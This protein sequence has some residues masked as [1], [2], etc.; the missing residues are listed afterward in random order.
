MARGREVRR[1]SEW[2]GRI[3]V[4]DTDPEKRAA[5]AL[6][7]PAVKAIVQ[8]AAEQQRRLHDTFNSPAVKALVQQAA[9]QQRRLHGTFN[10][11]AVKAIVQQAAEQQRRLHDTFNSP[12]VKA[13]V[14]Q[15]AE[16]QRRL[17]DTFNS[18]AAK[19]IVQ[20]AAEQQRRLHDT[21]NS[22]AAKVFLQ[23]TAEQQRRVRDGL[24]SLA[25][26]SRMFVEAYRAWDEAERRI[27]DLLVPRGWI[28]SP[29]TPLS[30][31]RALL[32]IADTEGVEAAERA[33][34]ETLDPS[35]CRRIV[36][37]ACDRPSFAPWQPVLGQALDAHERGEYALAV[38]VWLIAIDGIA[39]TELGV[40]NFFSKVHKKRQGAAMKAH[41]R[42]GARERLVDALLD[43]V[44]T[45]AAHVR[46]G[47]TSGELRRH[48]I[49][50]GLDPAYGSEKASIQG[51]LLLEA[52]HF[53][54]ELAAINQ[55][56]GS[57]GAISP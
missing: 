51:V 6:N 11:P 50:H 47:A 14:Q 42:Q 41:L 20:Q 39:L 48:A 54:L 13:I 10:S 57:A 37:K 4:A 52:L 56:G 16:Q 23:Q 32:A 9:E 49:L 46:P 22:P 25:E 27:L 36:E 3:G 31:I 21:F 29:D 53:Q 45:V 40:G 15:A 28:I 43:V 18:P 8:Q 55:A 12:A 34:I 1:S 17:H 44:R 38:P 30:E 35:A 24:A 5:E 19:A 33:L 2:R 7:S 26:S